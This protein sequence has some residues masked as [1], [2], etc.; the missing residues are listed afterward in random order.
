MPSNFR[1][2]QIAPFPPAH[3]VNDLIALKPNLYRFQILGEW[4]DEAIITL[5]TFLNTTAMTN[6]VPCIMRND[7][8]PVSSNPVT[9]PVAYDSLVA[10]WEMFIQHFDNEPRIIGYDLLNEPKG[11]ASQVNS[12]NSRLREHI[13]TKTKKKLVVSS[14]YGDPLKF[15]NLKKLPDGQLWYEAHMYLPMKFTHQGIYNNPVGVPWANSNANKLYIKDRLRHV[16]AFQQLHNCRIY[17][18]EFGVS[19]YADEQS[20]INY[21][22]Q[23]ISVF[24]EYGWNWSYHAWREADVW[25]LEPNVIDVMKTAWAKNG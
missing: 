17:I 22:T 9:D 12:F 16:R 2:A 18:G 4:F 19:K 25:N 5:G 8:D 10:K 14:P 7:A 23:C 3:D 13:R 21:L 1:G 15:K 20:R 24:E 11:T 6:V